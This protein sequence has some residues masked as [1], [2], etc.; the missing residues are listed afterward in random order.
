MVL[1]AEGMK[2]LVFREE[3]RLGYKCKNGVR[4]KC[5]ASIIRVTRIGEL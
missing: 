5:S 2:N 3:V 4:E 1:K